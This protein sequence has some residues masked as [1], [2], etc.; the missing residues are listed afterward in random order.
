LG[1]NCCCERC[2]WEACFEDMKQINREADK[3]R[4]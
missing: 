1:G 3:V 2:L 4:G